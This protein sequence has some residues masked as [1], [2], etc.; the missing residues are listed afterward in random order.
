M[1]QILQAQPPMSNENFVIPKMLSIEQMANALGVSATWMYRHAGE[2]NP[3]RIG[4]LLRFS[5]S[6]TLRLL[7][8]PL[9]TKYAPPE[10]NC[11]MP[12]RKVAVGFREYQ[13]GSIYRKG[14][15]WMGRWRERVCN[16]EGVTERVQRH[17]KL[18]TIRELPTKNAARK[19]LWELMRR[20]EPKVNITFAELAERWKQL[21]V[22]TM[23]LP[24][25][26]NYRGVLF[27]HVVPVLGPMQLNAI[28]PFQMQQFLA[29]KMAQGY[30]TN[31]LKSM[32]ISTSLVFRWAVKCGWLKE[33]PCAGVAIPKSGKKRVRH[34]LAP[35]QVMALVGELPPREAVMVAL[36]AITGLRISEAVALRWSDL[37]GASIQMRRYRY[38]GKTH[39]LEQDESRVIPLPPTLN[40][41][42]ET[43]RESEDDGWIFRSQ[44]PGLP[45]NHGMSLKQKI[46]P[47]LRR[48]KLP[49]IGWH[50]FRHT[51]ISW[52]GN[53]RHSPKMIADV[54]GHR[55]IATTLA[56][57]THSAPP[58]AYAALDA[59]AAKLF[60]NV[61]QKKNADVKDVEK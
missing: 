12:D 44:T 47:A 56:I 22:P 16:A 54:V 18:G 55:D 43:L 10:E 25:G 14:D 13:E 61:P 50:D 7:S 40:L 46:K 42:L 58:E 6:Q 11:L 1:A 4:R 3:V 19:R 48:L 20:A 41:L 27:R 15:S 32:K 34:V 60:H 29:E 36:L 37:Q 26:S 8:V 57:Y 39:D 59:I 9:A 53:A 31:Y 49:S 33:N 23:E 52:L 51:L 5:E 2:F 21:V 45:M 17:K 35:E 30:S 28:G 24:T 38:E